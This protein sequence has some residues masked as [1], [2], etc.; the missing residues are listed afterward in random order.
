M[1]TTNSI[2]YRGPDYTFSPL[3]DLR[4]HAESINKIESQRISVAGSGLTALGSLLHRSVYSENLRLS[5]SDIEGIAL[6]IEALGNHVIDLYE[7]VE[8]YSSLMLKKLDELEVA[9]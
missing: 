1:A 3:R 7:D 6:A 8:K 2:Q 5:E 4:G 9:S